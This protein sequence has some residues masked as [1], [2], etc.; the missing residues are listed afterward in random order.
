MI[1]ML[2]SVCAGT[3]KLQWLCDIGGL[4]ISLHWTV[5]NEFI[6]FPLFKFEHKIVVFWLFQRIIV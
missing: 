5:S 2:C 6:C 1:I 3:T 4:V